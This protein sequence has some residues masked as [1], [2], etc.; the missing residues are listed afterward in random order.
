MPVS[1]FPPASA[2]AAPA[3]SRPAAAVSVL[4]IRPPTVALPVAER[5]RRRGFAPFIL[6]LSR[7]ETRPWQWPQSSC[8]A[9]LAGSANAFLVM[10]PVPAAFMTVPV[11]C[12]GSKTAQ[13]ARAKG[14]ANI[15]YSAENA[16]DLCR[17]L[18]Q[19]GR[20]AVKSGQWLYLAGQKHRPVI[21][22][23]LAAE[24]I[25]Y[26]IICTY[27]TIGQS[28]TK[29]ELAALP[30]K[31]DYVL[32]YSALNAAHLPVLKSHIAAETKILCLSPRIAAALPPPCRQQAFIAQRPTEAA[33]L[34]LLPPAA[35]CA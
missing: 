19:A 14:F 25:A 31:L 17:F 11:Y 13:A 2:G 9:L 29:A 35:R 26:H 28:P 6:P 24:H 22:D 7:I 27:D 20:P 8:A 4:I 33:L 5:L 21:E 18:Q 3:K 16:E 12:V 1:A 34:A 32:L 15:A 10:P 23:F 30:P